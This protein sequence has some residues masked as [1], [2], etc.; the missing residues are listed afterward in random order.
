ML[1]MHNLMLPA[2]R[3]DSG[4]LEGLCG[5]R[6]ATGGLRGATGALCGAAWG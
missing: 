5:L 3:G 6:G 4:G 2:A 1:Q